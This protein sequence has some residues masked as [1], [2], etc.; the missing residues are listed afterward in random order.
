MAVDHGPRLTLLPAVLN[1]WILMPKLVSLGLKN[2][3][4]MVT[5]RDMTFKL[6]LI[7]LFVVYF[8]T[9]RLYSIK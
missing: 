2:Q 9:I 4:L 5:Y 7:H 1:H 8:M 6:N 3:C